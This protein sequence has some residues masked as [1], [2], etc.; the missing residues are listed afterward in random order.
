MR[1][2]KWLIGVIVVAVFGLLGTGVASGARLP[3]IGDVESYNIAPGKI[4][5]WELA[6]TYVCTALT[7]PDGSHVS[8]PVCKEACFLNP[9][10]DVPF[11]DRSTL[12]GPPPEPTSSVV[13]SVPFRPTDKPKKPTNTAL[14]QEPGDTPVPTAQPTV[15]RAPLMPT[16]TDIPEPT[17]TSVLFPTKPPPTEVPTDIP[18]Q[19][20]TKCL[21]H[22]DEKAPGKVTWVTKC[23]KLPKQQKAYDAHLNHGD[24][25]GACE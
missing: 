7:S 21:C 22:K 17:A 13:T 20:A 12:T 23:F 16:A 4:Y 2:N 10:G 9:C 11:V 1:K 18:K 8:D 15:T 6:G 3:F 25:K 24:S 19:E 5:A 14:P